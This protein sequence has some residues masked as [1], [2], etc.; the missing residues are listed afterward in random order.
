MYVKCI[1]NL[2]RDCLTVFQNIHIT[3]YSYQQCIKHSYCC[4]FL[5]INHIVSLWF[6][7][8]LF[9]YSN[10][11]LLTSHYSFKF[12]SV[13]YYELSN[14]PCILG[15]THLLWCNRSIHVAHFK[16]LGCSLIVF[17][18]LFIYCRFKSISRYVLCKCFLPVY[19][20]FYSFF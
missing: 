13:I 3:L 1:F 17:W 12:H 16:K 5:P 8:F 20:S 14:F 10:S 6:L 11:C 2:I 7:G 19:D 15:S 9:S 18:E 4:I